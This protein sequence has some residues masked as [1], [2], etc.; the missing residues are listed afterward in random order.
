MVLINPIF[1]LPIDVFEF[2]RA[3]QG[4]SLIHF[5]QVFSPFFLPI[6]VFEFSRALQ[7]GSLIHFMQV[8]SPFFLS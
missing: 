2:S 7:G 6:D 8:F 3:P 4:G 1:F 5:M